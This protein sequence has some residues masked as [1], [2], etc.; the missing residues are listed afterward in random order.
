MRLWR[1]YSV[2]LTTIVAAG[3]LMAVAGVALLLLT[4]P[5]KLNHIDVATIRIY[6]KA[7]TE[8]PQ[9]SLLAGEIKTWPE[10]K[11][12]NMLDRSLAWREYA[13][14]R[15]IPEAAF[16]KNPLPHV[17]V[18]ELINASMAKGVV[19]KLSQFD[20]DIELTRIG[21]PWAEELDNLRELAFICFILLILVLVKV[22]KDSIALFAL[23]QKIKLKRA[24]LV[25]TGLWIGISGGL[26]ACLI[27]ALIS[28]YF[29]GTLVYIS[30]KIADFYHILAISSG[31]GLFT[32]LMGTTKL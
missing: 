18:I 17:L 29:I 23:Q 28:G 25:A 9:A 26:F 4:Q 11:S 31:I 10:I 30:P 21:A 13:E 22:I 3:S 19:E 5:Q 24:E 15:G 32:G 2:G 1:F 12:I 7:G 6:L 14:H 27:A 20:D 16:A 8:Q